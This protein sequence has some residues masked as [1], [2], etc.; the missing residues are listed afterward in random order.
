MK[1]ID[2]SL[3]QGNVTFRIDPTWGVSKDKESIINRSNSKYLNRAV[4]DAYSSAYERCKATQRCNRAWNRYLYSPTR[5]KSTMQYFAGGEHLDIGL[6]ADFE[7]W[8]QGSLG[9]E[10]NCDWNISNPVCVP[11]S[12]DNSLR[13]IQ[14]GAHW[15][16][17]NFKSLG[18]TIPSFNSSSNNGLVLNREE[19]QSQ[20]VEQYQW[21]N[22][23]KGKI[24]WIKSKKM[25]TSL[26]AKIISRIDI[27]NIMLQTQRDYENLLEKEDRKLLVLSQS[28]CM[29]APCTLLFNTSNLK[30]TGAI[31]ATGEVAL[32]SDETEVAVWSFDSINLGSE[33]TV[34]I[35][36][37][38]AMALLS[39]SSVRI[40]TTLNSQSGTL[41]GFPGGYSSFREKDQRL[42]SVCSENLGKSIHSKDCIPSLLC[43]PGDRPLSQLTNETNSNNINGPGSGS[44]R[45]Y[46]H[47]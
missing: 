16:P 6:F 21:I 22:E 35:T 12:N 5:G 47:T 23:I 27:T 24:D 30:L 7:D 3:Y 39:K 1:D 46:L 43:C 37:Q 36:G 41:G 26:D 2:S 10:Q 31:N 25:T 9:W 15:S 44:V 40:N 20:I 19:L 4:D 8:R 42:L 45:V 32:T 14:K 29:N 18:P 38:R 13:L 11:Q 28:Q 33:V 34:N 17:F